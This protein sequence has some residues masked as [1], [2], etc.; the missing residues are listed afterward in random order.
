MTEDKKTRRA[1]LERR[2]TTIFLMALLLV[3]SLVYC[4]IEWN[5]VVRTERSTATLDDIIED[6]DL[7]LLKKD[8]D[9]VAAISEIDIKEVA[10]NVVVTIDVDQ[11]EEMLTPVEEEEGEGSDNG[12]VQEET[13]TDISPQLIIAT[14]NDHEKMVVMEKMPEFPGGASAFMKW[15]TANLKYPKSAR[16]KKIEGRVVVSFIVDAEGNTTNLKLEEA[17]NPTMGSLVMSVMGK[18]PKWEPGVQEGRVCATMIKV[19]INFEL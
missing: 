10:G 6:I 17:S 18:M 3:V 1:N 13:E 9:M 8:F 11:P 12:Q 2:R 5:V 19:P 7:D 16:E 14:L 15:L 4:A